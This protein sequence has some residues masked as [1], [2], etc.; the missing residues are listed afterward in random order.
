MKKI[1]SLVFVSALALSAAFAQVLPSVGFKN[2]LWSGF[3]QQ[4]PEYKNAVDGYE[5]P[6]VRFYGLYETLQARVDIAQFTVEGMLNW[7]A[8]TM[9]NGDNDFTGLKFYNTKKTAF[10]YTNNINQGDYITNGETDSYYVNFLWNI[11]GKEKH[12][13]DF[14]VG[15]RLEWKIGPAPTCYGHYW[16]PY[17]HVSQGG[18]KAA[19]PGAADVAGFTRYDN[20][21]ADHAIGLRYRYGDFIEIGTSIPDGATTN[22]LFVN[23]AFAVKPADFFRAAVAFYEIGSHS[24]DMYTGLSLYFSKVNIDAYLQ[25]NDI[26]NN[27]EAKT[28]GTGATFTFYPAKNFMIRP[29][30]G[31]TV[32]RQ[33]YITPAWYVGGRLN[34]DINNKISLG[35]FSSLAW[36]ASNDYWQD[37]DVA[38][39][40]K[41]GIPDALTYA[42]T[43]SWYGGFIFDVRPDITFIL[44]QRSSISA[45]FD[46]Q[47]RIAY[48]K[49]DY[50][51][52]G[53]GIYWTYRR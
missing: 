22:S 27:D 21:Y 17:A 14:G 6:N 25:I 18:L 10:Y 38:E 34:W 31:V 43:K 2:T 11:Y 8:E 39:R 29:E 36:G 5:T 44:D 16:E 52:W 4:F 20:I 50:S 47:Y 28:W 40:R 49:D 26:G 7:A 15:T 42:V 3:G 33:S 51:V 30:G 1:L 19:A 53:T 35:A 13:L 41:H 24:T 37:D 45:A 23:A 46:Y 48:N 32:Y 12:D 9:W